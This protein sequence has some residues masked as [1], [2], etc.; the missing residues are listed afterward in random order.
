MFAPSPRRVEMPQILAPVKATLR[1][2]AAALTAAAVCEPE[3]KS[4]A[5]EKIELHQNA[6]VV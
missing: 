5:K 6:N 2:P 1:A 3:T 4:E